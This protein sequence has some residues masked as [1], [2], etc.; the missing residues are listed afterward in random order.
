M[1]AAGIIKK[2]QV[3]LLVFKSRPDKIILELC[4]HF[5][6]KG[7]GM[8]L[9]S[10]PA[11][12][13]LK[14]LENSNIG[15]SNIFLI[16]CISKKSRKS[17]HVVYTQNPGALTELSTAISQML[18]SKKI[19]IVII[20]SISSLLIYNHDIT[21]VRFLQELVGKVRNTNKKL[22]LAILAKDNKGSLASVPLFVDAVVKL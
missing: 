7:I 11:E 5:S 16:D 2:N 12:L 22:V 9:S 10:N 6:S 18:K 1:K 14:R 4:R 8:I 13:V 3:V 15:C 20:D 19:S 21:L 17:E